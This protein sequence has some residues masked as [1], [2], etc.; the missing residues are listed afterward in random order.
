MRPCDCQLS[1]SRWTLREFQSPIWLPW[2][3]DL[4]QESVLEEVGIHVQQAA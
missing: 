3:S 2:Y 1:V 4:Q